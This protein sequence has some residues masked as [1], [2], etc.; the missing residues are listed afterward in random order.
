MERTP[1]PF[2]FEVI[3]SIAED[4]GVNLFRGYNARETEVNVHDA[5]RFVGVSGI[6]TYILADIHT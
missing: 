1:V 5:G 2:E 6:H 3:S 4:K